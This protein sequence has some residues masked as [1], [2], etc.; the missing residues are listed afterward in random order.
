M[1]LRLDNNPRTHDY[2]R[3]IWGHALQGLKMIPVYREPTFWQRLCGQTREHVSNDLTCTGHGSVR[4]GDSIL[5]E[6]ASGK[7]AKWLVEDIKHYRDP[8]DMF[9][10]RR[11]SFVEYVACADV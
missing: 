8:D 7:I 10:I 5:I 1:L 2:T 9:D 4:K 3:M 6:M 11:A